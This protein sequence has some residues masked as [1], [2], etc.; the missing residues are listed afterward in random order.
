MAIKYTL[1]S[2]LEFNC[3]QILKIHPHEKGKITIKTEKSEI[4]HIRID[5]MLPDSWALP[6]PST[7]VYKMV[8]WVRNNSLETHDTRE[9]LNFTIE[10]VKYSKFLRI[11][12][13]F[14]VESA[15]FGKNELH[16]N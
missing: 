13:Q 5:E 8:S 6:G 7:H 11:Y 16:G 15:F 10:I 2:L 4:G 3:I 12:G 14:S 1:K 9:I